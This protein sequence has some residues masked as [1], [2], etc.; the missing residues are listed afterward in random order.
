L[1]YRPR[2]K[3]SAAFLY[4]LT[5]TIDLRQGTASFSFR[6]HPPNPNPVIPSA[7]ARAFFLHRETRIVRTRRVLGGGARRSRG[8]LQLPF[9]FAFAAH[10]KSEI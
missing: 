7:D 8:I 6:F 2:E 9:A 3:T 1:T 4:A 5:P 10:L